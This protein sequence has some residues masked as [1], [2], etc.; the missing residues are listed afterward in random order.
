MK[1]VI[2]LVLILL[3]AAILF[4]FRYE[5]TVNSPIIVKLDRWT[6]S[7]SVANNGTWMAI[8]N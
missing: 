4:L 5:I 3:I 6:G 1:S 2:I 7:A 8:Q